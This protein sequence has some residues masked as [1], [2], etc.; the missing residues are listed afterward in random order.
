VT[1]KAGLTAE[2]LIVEADVPYNHSHNSPSS[3]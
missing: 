2:G 3:T 1:T